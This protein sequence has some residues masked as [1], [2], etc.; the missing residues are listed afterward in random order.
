MG[1]WNLALRADGTVI[2]WGSPLYSDVPK[3]PN[4]TNV[5]AIVSGYGYA[6]VLKADGTLEGWGR[7]D[8]ATNIPSGA[9]QCRRF[10]QR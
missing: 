8:D 7:A 5:Q 10:R 4:V 2:D 3:P 1:W 6:E 9:Q